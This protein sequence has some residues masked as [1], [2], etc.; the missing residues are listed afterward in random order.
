MSTSHRN[1]QFPVQRFYLMRRSLIIRGAKGYCAILQGRQ[2]TV[3]IETAPRVHVHR[4]PDG[5]RL[6]SH[7]SRLFHAARDHR[8]ILTTI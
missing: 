6:R 8:Q 3:I 5:R 4:T 7:D 2:D 1:A